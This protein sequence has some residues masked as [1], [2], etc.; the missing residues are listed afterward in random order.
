MPILNF[1][2]KSADDEK[3]AAIRKAVEKLKKEN[4]FQ[5]MFLKYFKEPPCDD[6]GSME[7]SNEQTT[8]IMELNSDQ[9]IKSNAVILA[10]NQKRVVLGI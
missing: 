8:R 5:E 6:A 7:R 2:N 3:I 9:T 4:Y 1:S 10:T